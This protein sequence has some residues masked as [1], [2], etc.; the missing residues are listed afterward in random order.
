MLYDGVGDVVM[1]CRCMEEVG[2]NVGVV[3]EKE[4]VGGC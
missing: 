2:V 3:G 4:C 1:W